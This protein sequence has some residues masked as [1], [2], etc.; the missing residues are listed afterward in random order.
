MENIQWSNDLSVG[1]ELVDDQHKML[2]QRLNDVASAI[3]AHR[4]EGEVGKTIDFLI[5]YTD[6]HFSEEEKHM[7]ATNYPEFKQ[8][9][10]LHEEFKDTLNS[11]EQDFRDD[12][13]CPPLV[14]AVN[15]LLMNWLVKHIKGTD[16]KF[17]KY[18]TENN[19]VISGE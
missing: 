16:V 10:K 2:I 18:L 15:T 11:L 6:F 3:E 5:K 4:G 8:H 12:G 19:I 9:K 7:T 17:G 14:T 13:I 1:I